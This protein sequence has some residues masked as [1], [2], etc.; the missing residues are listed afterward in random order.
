MRNSLLR[1]ALSPA[2]AVEPPLL[3]LKAGHLALALAGGLCDG[4]VERDDVRFLAKGTLARKVCQTKST[5]KFNA[6]GHKIADV[7]VFRTV[8]VMNVRCL[9]EDGSI[10]EYTSN[11][12]EDISGNH[13][14]DGDP[15]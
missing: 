4:I 2:T 6:E 11:D 13:T 7:N 9:R 5:E 8:Y 10:E 12:G 15:A 1:E 3:P 14:E